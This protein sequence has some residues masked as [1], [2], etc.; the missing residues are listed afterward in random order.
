MQYRGVVRVFATTQAPD[1][2]NPWQSRTPQSSTGSGVVIRSR[3]ILTGAHVVADATFLQ[4]QKIS[5]P[6]KVL[7]RV[8]AICHDADLA[9]LSV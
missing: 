9:L 2:D 1:H 3:Q 8:A 7:A 4:V 5:S 6:E